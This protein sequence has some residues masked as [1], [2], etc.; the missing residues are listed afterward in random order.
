[1]SLL[2]QLFSA[3]LYVI[4]W[5]LLP[6]TVFSYAFIYYLHTIAE[7]LTLDVFAAATLSDWLIRRHF[8]YRFR[9]R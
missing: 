8:R 2:R 9:F 7:A 4:R 6:L 5:P 1:M 3:T